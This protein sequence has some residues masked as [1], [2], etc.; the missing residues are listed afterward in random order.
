MSLPVKWREEGMALKNEEVYRILNNLGLDDEEIESINKRNKMLESSVADEI[1]DVVDFFKVKCDFDNDDMA[2]LII[3]NPF[4]LNE[5]FD[6]ISVLEKFYSN[7]GFS[8]EEYKMY[9]TNF[10][11]AFSL[12]PKDVAEEVTKLLSDGNN[13]EYIKYL[14][15]KRPNQIFR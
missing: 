1:S 8:K 15:I 11:K 2:R 6:R 10:S 3:K 7:L 9:L 5:N 4:I 14:M 13:M 12:N